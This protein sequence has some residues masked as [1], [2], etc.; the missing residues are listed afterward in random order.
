MDESNFQPDW[1]SAPGGTI[2]DV[3]EQKG[4]SEKDLAALLNCSQ[5]RVEKLLAGKEAITKERRQVA[6]GTARR[7]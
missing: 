7:V 5:R 1:F 3:L 6:A 2:L 4:M